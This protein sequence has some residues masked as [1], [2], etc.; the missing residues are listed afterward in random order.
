[1][2]Q[3]QS[4]T[5]QVAGDQ[6][7]KGATGS[8]STEPKSNPADLKNSKEWCEHSFRHGPDGTVEVGPSTG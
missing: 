3:T 2:A 6:A 5:R 1:M 4:E 7:G 8:G